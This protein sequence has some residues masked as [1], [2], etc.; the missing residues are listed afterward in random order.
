MTVEI[1]IEPKFKKSSLAQK[2]F[3][4]DNPALDKKLDNFRKN[5]EWLIKNTE[6]LRKEY[7]DKYVAVYNG[8][9]C[10]AEKNPIKLLK[11]AKNRYGKDQS[12]V[13]GFIGKEK[14]NFR[15]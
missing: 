7:G 5:S 14:I 12:L 6:N 8:K 11:H 1:M 3:T 10:L 15:F 13:L 4:A 9:I 2:L